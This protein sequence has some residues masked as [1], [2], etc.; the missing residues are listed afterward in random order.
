MKI[1]NMQTQTEQRAA[2]TGMPVPIEAAVHKDTSED[3][4]ETPFVLIAATN[5]PAESTDAAPMAWLVDPLSHLLIPVPPDQRHVPHALN[6]DKQQTVE[7]RLIKLL[8]MLAAEAGRVVDRQRLID[9]LWPRVVVNDN[10][11][12]RAVSDL[13]KVLQAHNHLWIQTIPKR[14]YRLN[15]T[16][17]P[18]SPAPNAARRS[19]P[20]TPPSGNPWWRWTPTAAAAVLLGI[21]VLVQWV[22]GAESP[23][24]PQ[25]AAMPDDR[26][27]PF[28]PLLQASSQAT[29]VNSLYF[30][31]EDADPARA[32]SPAVN[33]ADVARFP[34]LLENRESVATDAPP[35]AI[36]V[37]A[38][39]LM[40]YVDRHEGISQ[41]KLR[42]AFANDTPWVA[43]TTDEKIQHLQWSPLDDGLLF[44]V[45]NES[46]EVGA[47]SYMR[48]MLLDMETLSLHELYRR[49]I[50]PKLEGNSGKLT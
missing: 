40:A 37:T 30:S 50:V 49:E 34:R 2:D 43:F 14:G 3:I 41:L 35:P 8:C 31:A 23:I 48:L 25:L 28:E 15:A 39:Q 44:T 16:A 26:L 27:V 36:M 6:T 45:G 19:P 33:G 11:L 10:S 9:A 1:T 21:S 18:L 20:V 42:H 12:N 4:L 38:H 17:R 47:S 7:P 29:V 5:S 13:R 24:T 32:D 22:P 46:R